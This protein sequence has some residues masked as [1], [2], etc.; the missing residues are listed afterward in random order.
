MS[1]VAA[2]SYRSMFGR[3]VSQTK[4]SSKSLPG[5][6]RSLASLLIRLRLVW[7]I[8]IAFFLLSGCGHN[9]LAVIASL[10]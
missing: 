3:S 10:S 2:R 7:L 4:R 8:P 9:E 1:R 6:L 5:Q